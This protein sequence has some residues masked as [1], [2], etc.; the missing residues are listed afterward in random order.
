M[1]RKP[2]KKLCGHFRTHETKV[3]VDDY[4]EL[5]TYCSDCRI[6]V[7]VQAVSPQ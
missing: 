7:K 6:A 5:V 1:P 2:P 4:V 3:Y